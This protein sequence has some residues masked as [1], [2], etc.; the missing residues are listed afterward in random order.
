MESAKSTNPE[1]LTKTEVKMKESKTEDADPDQL[2]KTE[3]NMM[4]SKTEQADPKQ[5][6]KTEF[7]MELRIEPEDPEQLA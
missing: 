2:P 1:Q 4:E 7:K 3:V 6:T 5:F